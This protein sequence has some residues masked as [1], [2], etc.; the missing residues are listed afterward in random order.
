MV[1]VADMNADSIRRNARSLLT[2]LEE[3]TGLVAGIEKLTARH[4][5]GEN[6]TLERDNK[7]TD[8]WL[9]LVDPNTGAILARESAFVKKYV[10]Y[11]ILM[12]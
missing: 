11:S 8:M 10:Q 4:Y 12:K 2:V 9:Y 3:K 6:G 1:E 7:G 5:L